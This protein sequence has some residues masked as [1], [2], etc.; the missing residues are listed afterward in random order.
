MTDA[1]TQAAVERKSLEAEARELA[2]HMVSLDNHHAPEVVNRAALSALDDGADMVCRLLSALANQAEALA[3]L[4]KKLE[5]MTTGRDWFHSESERRAERIKELEG[6]INRA[7]RQ[8]SNADV[9]ELSRVIDARD[10]LIMAKAGQPAAPSLLPDVVALVKVL[11][12]FAVKSRFYGAGP[13]DS[14]IVTLPLRAFR[15]AEAALASFAD[16]VAGE[17]ETPTK[18][19]MTLNL[20]EEEMAALEEIAK[21]MDV[22]PPK[23]FRHGLKLMQLEVRR[24]AADQ[25]DGAS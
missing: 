8:L 9:H 18:K 3:E 6:A 19:T 21:A 4:E 23:V 12:P 2:S 20:T 24:L 17:E 16:R 11:E 10:T 5:H 22:S 15:A 1:T 25:R 13:S 14:L 7:V